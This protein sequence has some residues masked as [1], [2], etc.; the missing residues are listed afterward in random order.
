MLSTWS[1]NCICDCIP[2]KCMASSWVT[3]WVPSNIAS[4]DWKRVSI[5][6][7]L[8]LLYLQVVVLVY[9]RTSHKRELSEIFHFSFSYTWRTSVYASITTVEA[10]CLWNAMSQ[11]QNN[12]SVCSI[13]Y[14]MYIEIFIANWL[15]GR[16]IKY[17]NFPAK[18]I[19]SLSKLH[20]NIHVVLCQVSVTW[21]KRRC[22]GIPELHDHAERHSAF[23]TS[24]KWISLIF[25]FYDIFLVFFP[26][27]W[28]LQVYWH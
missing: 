8:F 10:R 5:V 18:Y 15:E 13:A 11:K 27:M 22:I 4:L 17:T 14:I 6:I 16:T 7:F 20:W 28:C 1:P 12:S 25:Y 26:L 23:N 24:S 9:K 19:N 2:A 3:G 21:N